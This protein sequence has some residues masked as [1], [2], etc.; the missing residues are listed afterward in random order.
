[1]KARAMVADGPDRLELREFEVVKPRPDQV[2]IRT[3]VTS[4]C[5]SDPK[6][7]HGTAPLS[8]F[9]LILGHELAGEVAEIGADAAVVYGLR[10][11]DRV[12]IEPAIPCG[13]CH[14]CRTEFN[15]HKCRPLVAYGV[16]LSSA[17]APHLFGGYAE[18]LYLLPGSHVYQLQDETPWLA[19]SLSSVIGNGVRW[20]RNLGQMTPGQRL[21]ISGA[22]SQGL[23][24]LIAARECGVGPIA[25]LGLNRDAARLA[26]ARE[27]GADFTVNVEEQNP[28]E[29]VPALLG[30]PPDVVVETSGAPA[31]IQAAID[32]VRPLGRVAAIGLSGRPTTIRFDELVAKGVTILCDH[33]QAGNYP[34]AMRIINSGK[35]AIEKINNVHYRLEDLPRALDDTSNPPAGFIKGAIVF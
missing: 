25:V 16:T 24:S 35:Y 9:P 14:W 4:V 30:G 12:T 28:L 31:A 34:E 3:R 18:Y 22:G 13:R 23:A 21:A 17:A 32:L 7:L 33:A 6:I 10:P 11:G 26:L 20:I 8:T 19:G 27:F 15:Y 1:M 29:V 5:A 2:L